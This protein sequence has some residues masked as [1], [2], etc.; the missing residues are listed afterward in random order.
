MIKPENYFSV[1][2]GEDDMDA[3]NTTMERI[4]VL[5]ELLDAYLSCTDPSDNDVS[6]VTIQIIDSLLFQARAI[7][8]TGE[9]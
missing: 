9:K 4:G 6:T 3:Y 8:E 7:M 1:P 5:T 2:K